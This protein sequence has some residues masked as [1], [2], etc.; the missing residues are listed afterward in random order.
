MVAT[1]S[2]P[3]SAIQTSA[4]TVIDGASVPLMLISSGAIQVG[5]QYHWEGRQVLESGDKLSAVIQGVYWSLRVSGYQLTN[6]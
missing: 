5:A 1:F 4:L 6:P 2:G 3:S